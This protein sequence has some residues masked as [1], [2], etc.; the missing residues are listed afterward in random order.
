G[1]HTSRPSKVVFRFALSSGQAGGS[2]IGER[3]AN[4]EKS[5]FQPCWHHRN[6]HP[7]RTIRFILERMRCPHWHVGEHP[8]AGDDTLVADLEGNLSFDDVEALFLSG[9]KVRRWPAAWRHN[10]FKLGI[11]AIGVLAGCHEA[12]HITNEG[13]GA[14]LAGLADCRVH[15]VLAPFT[16]LATSP[17][18]STHAESSRSDHRR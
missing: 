3:R 10:G 5:L 4:L 16:S 13:N 11:F 14:A 15:F 7:G 9:V 6:E 1:H 12:V 2:A 18:T 17:Q 8:G